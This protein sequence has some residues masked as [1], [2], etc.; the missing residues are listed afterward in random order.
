MP[1]SVVGDAVLGSVA[2][3]VVGSI[4]GSDTSGQQG[5]AAADPF[6]SQRPQYQAM[7]SSLM[8]GG[9]FTSDP[10]Y[11]TR[12]AAG[13]EN[14]NRGMAATGQIGSGAQM[15][16]L[17]DYGQQQAST[18]YANQFSRLS[19][20]AGGNM[21]SPAAAGQIIDNANNRSNANVAQFGSQVG[22]AVTDWWK[23]TGGSMPPAYD[24]GYGTQPTG[25]IGSVDTGALG[26]SGPSAPT[27]SV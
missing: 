5:A 15:T 4:F 24:N 20:L 23:N 9:D 26:Y 2:S 13:T 19:Q 18:E 3:G 17:Q 21:G 14:L 22:S 11:K 25:N 6:A 1:F 8:N 7:L 12:L 10:S 27:F 16:A